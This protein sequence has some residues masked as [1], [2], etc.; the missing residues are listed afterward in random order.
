MLVSKYMIHYLVTIT[1]TFL[2][3]IISLQC[4]KINM[5][6]RQGPGEKKKPN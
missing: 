2:E 1:F 4:V 6:I 5:E 3:E